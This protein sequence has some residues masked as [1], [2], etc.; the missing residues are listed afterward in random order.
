M[1][2]SIEN[3]EINYNGKSVKGKK[4]TIY[5]ELNIDINTAWNEVQ[6]SSLLKFVCKGKVT[7]KPVGSEFPE[8]WKENMTIKTKMLIYGLIPFG[9]IHSLKF[10][11][12]EPEKFSALTNEKNSIVKIWNHRII[13]GKIDENRI[14]Y[15]DEIELNAGILTNFVSKWAESLYLHRQKR[16][17]IVANEIKTK[18]QH[19]I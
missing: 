11:E 5:S 12:V 6:K 16:W 14:K 4:L 13:M 7:F 19:R 3:I 2:S 15:T 10:A 17:K 8:Y 18:A 1:N 9:G